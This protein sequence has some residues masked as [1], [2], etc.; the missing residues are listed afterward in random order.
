M[1]DFEKL[2]AFYLGKVYDVKAQDV[3]EEVLLYDS[4]DLTT[5]AVCVGMTGS[6]KTGLCIGLIEEAAIDGIPAILIDPKGDLGNLLLTFPN[7]QGSDFL[8]WI[9]Q[10]EARNKD[11]SPEA[12]ADK[13]AALWS[14]GLNT[15]GQDGR[16]IQRLR[17]SAEMLIYTPGSNAGLPVSILNSFAAPGKEILEDNDLLRER[18]ST[19][20]SSLLG[21]VGIDA[22]PIQS[23]EH[24]LLSTILDSAWRSAK[25]LDLAALIQQVQTPP[26]QKVGVLDIET[27]YPSKER[28]GLVMALNNLLASPGFNAWLEGTPLDIGQILYTPA[29]KPRIAIFSIAHL[30]DPERMFFVSLLMNQ[31][32]G[33]MRTQPGTNS[34]RAIVYMDEI[35]GYLPPTAN[36]PSKTPMLTLLKQ[37]RAFGVGMV[38]ATQNPVDLDYKALSNM[39]TWFIGRLQTERDKARLLDGLES[40]T[41]RGFNRKQIEKIIS[42]LGNRVFLVN[43]THEDAPELFQTRWA[44]SYLRGPLTRDQIKTLMEP[45][46]AGRPAATSSGPKLVSV[47]GSGTNSQPPALPPG[48]NQFYIPARGAAPAGS[49]LVYQPKILGAAKIHYSDTRAKEDTSQS[50]VCVTPVTEDAIPVL[51]EN[52]ETIDLPATDLEKSPRSGAQ[53]NVLPPAASQA[54]NYAAWEKDF[55]TWLYGS[56]RLDL[57]QSPGLKATSNPGEDERDFRIRLQQVAREQRDEMIEALRGKYAAKLAALQERKRRAEQTLEKQAEQAKKAKLDTALSVGATLLG[58]FTGRKMLSQSN[59]SKAKSAMRGVSKSADEGQDVKRAQET[60]EAIDGQIADL[61]A[62]F[63]ADT[64]ELESKI[65]PLAE[66]LETFSLKPKKTDIQVQLTTLAW[67]PYWKDKQEKLT[68]AW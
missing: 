54:K 55:G 41:G 38:F 62:Q 56:Q 13:Q 35:F 37:A 48:L 50:V 65:D 27:F 4:K 45:V 5:H 52:A 46:K 6:G 68:P 25:N 43:N 14:K 7:L 3:K 9:N 26:V 47:M 21:L 58:A 12:Y 28:F 60:V 63:E 39:G 24:I 33:W 29:G 44:L 66:A 32:L 34:L 49:E 59:I 19:T 61:N 1:E 20:V 51:W 23:K 11:L 15:W 22:D 10:D 31:V 2:G 36:P 30:S 18:I 40:A 57:L 67:L 64:V 17:D 42:D 8:P 53:F 16:R